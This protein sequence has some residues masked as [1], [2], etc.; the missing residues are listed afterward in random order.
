MLIYFSYWDPCYDM[1]VMSDRVSLDLLY[2][3]TIQ[4]IDLGWIT[5]N[6]QT[7]DILNSHESRKEKKEVSL[8]FFIYIIALISYKAVSFSMSLCKYF[9][10]K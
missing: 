6:S 10:L 3:Q 4:D 9:F 7:R 1:D 2:L 8:I 5:V